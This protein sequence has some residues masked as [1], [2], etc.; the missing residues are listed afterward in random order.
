MVRKITCGI[1]KKDRVLLFACLFVPAVACSQFLYENNNA[2]IKASLK[3]RKETGYY[4]HADSTVCLMWVKRFNRQGMMTLYLDHWQCGK[5]YWHYGFE[6]DSNG[7]ITSSWKSSHKTDFI[8]VPQKHTYNSTG[9]LVERVPAGA[10]AGSV[11]E[12]FVYNTNG[13]ITKVEFRS[14]SGGQEKVER[15]N[16]WNGNKAYDLTPKENIRDEKGNFRWVLIREF[17]FFSDKP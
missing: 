3:V 4:K 11:K 13:E 17:E 12:Y 14:M 16:S 5:P 10:K 7:S 8:K 1:L 6:Y 15:S 9:Q 2:D